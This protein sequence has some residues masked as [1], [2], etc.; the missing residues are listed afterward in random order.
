[1]INFYYQS[2]LLKSIKG[3]YKKICIEWISTETNDPKGNYIK[4]NINKTFI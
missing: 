1:M 3:V 4:L 2:N